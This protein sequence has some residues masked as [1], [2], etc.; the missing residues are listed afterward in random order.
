MSRAV[1][2]PAEALD[3]ILAQAR[4][5]G[6]LQP[7]RVP[8]A[9]AAG[10]ALA[11]PL[12][13]RAPL[14]SFATSAM[15]GFA[16]RT[17]DLSRPGARLRIAGTVAAGHPWRATL[18]PGTCLRIFTGAPLPRG[19]DGVE[20]QER[21]S[22]RGAEARFERAGQSG[23][24][25]RPAGSDVAG[26]AVALPS[27]ARL[28]PGAIG[29]AAA[30]GFARVPVARRP[31]VAILATGD[32]V[33][34]LGRRP[35][36]GQI[37]ESNAHALAAAVREAGGEP[38]L[39]GI[40]PDRPAA[41]RRAIARSRSADV[42]LTVGGVSVGER[43]LVRAALAEAGMAVDFW[44]VAMRPGK[45]LLFGRLGR[46]LVFGLPGNPASALVAFELFA[47]PALRALVGLPGSG[48]VVIRA[49]LDVP[50]AKPPE[51]AVYLR[52]RVV[53][54]QGEAWAVPLRTQVSG[55][56][57]SSADVGALVL[58]PAG[59]ARFARR[60]RVEAILLG[61]VGEDVGSG[62]A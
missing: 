57:T 50:Q 38:R 60:S 18:R 23:R 11:A 49:R 44:R 14:P 4:R 34:P 13:A 10:R 31:V 62:P 32:E 16:V 12:R 9:E 46:T 53:S 8:L 21:V 59:R 52:S 20:M 55:D 61:P 58:L 29:L 1:I 47:R 37:V 24:F 19:A 48:R 7:E 28:D 3:R 27:G 35:G 54:R 6:P 36:L 56:L 41:L 33:V 45:P 25:V 2:T 17:D 5:L 43:D 39:L 51:L 26:G 30:L 40:A 42:L 15:D 22:V